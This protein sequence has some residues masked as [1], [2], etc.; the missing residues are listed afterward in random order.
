MRLKHALHTCWMQ[1]NLRKRKVYAVRRHSGSL[2][3]I[4]SVL[5]DTVTHIHINHVSYLTQLALHHLRSLWQ[6]C[7]VW[8]PSSPA[9]LSWLQWQ[10]PYAVHVCLYNTI[11]Q[12][13]VYAWHKA[14][15]QARPCQLICGHHNSGL[16]SCDVTLLH[17]MYTTSP[18][19][20][21]FVGD[22]WSVAIAY[23]SC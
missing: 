1:D 11:K 23:S 6:M 2:L 9:F 8:A 5:Q 15:R 16:I 12:H 3:Q 20:K 14:D 22:I 7:N 4:L 10:R 18:N 21:E 19:L 17:S 13:K